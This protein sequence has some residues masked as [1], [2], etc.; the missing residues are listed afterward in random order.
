MVD[1]GEGDNFGLVLNRPV[2]VLY[3]RSR[4]QLSETDKKNL[5]SITRIKIFYGQLCKNCVLRID[6][7]PHKVQVPAPRYC[8]APESA[9]QTRRNPQLLEPEEIHQ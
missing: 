6:E 1:G 5:F 7:G 9:N 4:Y 8:S 3:W 2:S